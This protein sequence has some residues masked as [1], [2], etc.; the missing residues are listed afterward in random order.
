MEAV[1][2]AEPAQTLARAEPLKRDAARL[3]WMPCLGTT[4]VSS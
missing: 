1:A 4:L 3:V 2:S